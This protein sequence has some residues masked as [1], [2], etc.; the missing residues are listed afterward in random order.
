MMLS[1]DATIQSTH[2]RD[3]QVAQACSLDRIDFGICIF[4][5]T[6]VYQT[7]STWCIAYDVVQKQVS[8]RATAIFDSSIEIFLGRWVLLNKLRS[9]LLVVDNE[10]VY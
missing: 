10:P 8:R 9:P 3:A 6:V 5:G 7:D 1:A 4:W 2:A